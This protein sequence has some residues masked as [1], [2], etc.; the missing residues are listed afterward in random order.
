MFTDIHIIKL[1]ISSQLAAII[2]RITSS[3]LRGAN[4]I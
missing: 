2:V 3:L 1:V 4:K